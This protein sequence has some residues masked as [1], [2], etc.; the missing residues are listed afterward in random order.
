M[1]GVVAAH[2]QGAR[3]PY[4]LVCLPVGGDCARVVVHALARHA[5]KPSKARA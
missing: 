2:I 3:I 1:E 4:D 5:L